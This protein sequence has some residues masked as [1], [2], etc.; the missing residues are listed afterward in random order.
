MTVGRSGSFDFKDG[1]RAST[2]QLGSIGAQVSGQRIE[3]CHKIV[4]ELD[5]HFTSSHSHMLSHMPAAQ[6]VTLEQAPRPRNVL[7]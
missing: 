2:H 4:V 5:Q 7:A 6:N 3:L 1:L